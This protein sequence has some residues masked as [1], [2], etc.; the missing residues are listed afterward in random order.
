MTMAIH[1]QGRAVVHTD[2]TESPKIFRA[3]GLQIQLC[4]VAE[5]M[6]EQDY[7]SYLTVWLVAVQFGNSLAVETLL[8]DWYN[9]WIEDA[10]NDYKVGD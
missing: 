1:E 6:R 8:A 4:A 2:G 3:M 7:F 10:L 9:S 5:V